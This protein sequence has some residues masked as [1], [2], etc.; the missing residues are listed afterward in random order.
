MNS[1]A[2]HQNIAAALQAWQVLVTSSHSWPWHAL[3]SR[4]ICTHIKPQFFVATDQLMTYDDDTRASWHLISTRETL[5]CATD[6]SVGTVC[7]A[8]Q[9][10]H[11][12]L[13]NQSP[14]FR[15]GATFC[16]AIYRMQWRPNTMRRKMAAR[17]LQAF[18]FLAVVDT[19][20][21]NKIMAPQWSSK[22]T[23]LT[24][25]I[26]EGD[27]T[28]FNILLNPKCSH[29][30]T[31]SQHCRQHRFRTSLGLRLRMEAPQEPRLW[32]SGGGA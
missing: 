18:R 14:T 7:L 11:S 3:Q 28:T 25:P 17:S 26:S 13:L 27:K 10:C 21:V 16:G 29:Q 5:K 20:L 23:A 24:S 32:G 31:I 9:V 15:L 19:Q 4:A 22:R 1:A 2:C 6:V 8:S 12:D 30:W